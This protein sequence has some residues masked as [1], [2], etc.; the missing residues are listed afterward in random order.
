MSKTYYNKLVRDRIPEII[1]S[2]GK[3]CEIEILDDEAYLKAL[4]DK[5]LEE[6]NEYRENPSIEELADI[7]TVLLT[8]GIVRFGGSGAALKRMDEK[9]YERGA[10]L[11]KILL[12]WVDDGKEV[13]DDTDTTEQ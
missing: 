6:V 1:K 2:Q 11:D 7:Y 10:F 3:T 13:K 5:L 9:M 4:E 12:K 8:I